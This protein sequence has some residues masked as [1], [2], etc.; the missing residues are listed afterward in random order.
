MIELT[1]TTFEEFHPRH[2]FQKLSTKVLKYMIGEI[3]IALY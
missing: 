1:K 3:D 2:F